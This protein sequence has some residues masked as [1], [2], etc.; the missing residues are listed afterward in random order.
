MRP[1]VEN[2]K[3]GLRDKI[4]SPTGSVEYQK[5]PLY[6]PRPA[7]SPSLFDRGERQQSPADSILMELPVDVMQG[8]FL[9][10]L[11]QF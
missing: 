4:N 6:S 11:N 3:E 8:G 2:S 5:H 10:D 1:K 7:D 9:D